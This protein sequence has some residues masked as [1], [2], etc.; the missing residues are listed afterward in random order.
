MYVITTEH[1]EIAR[2]ENKDTAKV[3]MYAWARYTLTD[4]YLVNTDGKEIVVIGHSTPKT[5]EEEDLPR[6][7]LFG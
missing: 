5:E 1:E 4:T 2:T 7:E 6:F 3:L